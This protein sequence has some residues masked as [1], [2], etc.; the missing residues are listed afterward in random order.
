MID[1]GREQTLYRLPAPRGA[2]GAGVRGGVCADPGGSGALL[3]GSG[4]GSAG[5]G[6]GAGGVGPGAAL[7]SKTKSAGP[8]FSSGPGH[9]Y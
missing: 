7:T 8:R 2:R 4:D 9:Q 3:A 1:D 6:G 5:G